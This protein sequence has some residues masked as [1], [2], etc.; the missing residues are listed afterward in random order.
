MPTL[1]LLHVYRDRARYI[2]SFREYQNQQSRSKACQ[3]RP[4]GGNASRLFRCH[5]FRHIISFSGAFRILNGP[6]A[7]K[8]RV[9]F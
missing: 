9:Y 4:G 6:L 7:T 8:I 2:I 3:S 1:G 5:R